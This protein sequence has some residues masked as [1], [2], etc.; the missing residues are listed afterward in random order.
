MATIAMTAAADRTLAAA[1]AILGYAII[2][3]FTDNFVRVIAADAGLWQFHALR[4]VMAMAILGVAAR[5]LGLRLAPQNLGAVAGRSLIHGCAMLI[6]FGC[7]AFLPVATVAA[8]LF[9]API[10]VLLIS[11]FAFGHPVGPYRIAAVLIGFLGV[12]LV[13]GPASGERIGA[14]TVL[15][16]AAGALY[17][18]G[19]LATREWCAGE[20]AET[21]LAGFFVTLG[22]FGLIGMAVLALWP[23]PVPEGAAG[24]VLRGATVP[25]G[26]FLFWTFVQAAGSLIGV[27]LMIRA[28]QIAAA[29]RVAIFEYVI[30]PA[31]ALW[32][33]LLWAELV[34][35]RAAL[36]M[37]LIFLAGLII[38][39]RRR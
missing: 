5:P 37:G 26:P 7:L 11:R 27:G 33:Y 15:P 34:S 24:F 22:L 16:V 32:S 29:S 18:L 31:S 23:V 3:G 28:Y 1:A 35:P 2:I 30:L 17:A 14:A 4:G 25:T 19:N 36:G 38:V 13:L 9:T 6:Y 12:I 10:F 39:L 8:G 20:T 21:L